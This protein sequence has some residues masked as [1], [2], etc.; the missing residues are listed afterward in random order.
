MASFPKLSAATKDAPLNAEKLR[1]LLDSKTMEKLFEEHPDCILPE[2]ACR[3]GQRPKG[4]G[5]KAPFGTARLREMAQAHFEEPVLRAIDAHW[6]D[7]ELFD[8]LAA[9]EY[10]LGDQCTTLQVLRAWAR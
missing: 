6:F 5:A 3:S 8:F 2:S 10:P 9:L 7:E 4:L 1:A